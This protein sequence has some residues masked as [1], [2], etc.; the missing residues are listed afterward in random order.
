MIIIRYC[1]F[2]TKD[3]VLGEV[4]AKTTQGTKEDIDLAVE[5]ARTAFDTWSSLSNHTRALHIYSIARHVQKHMRLIS[6]IE[7]LDN[8]KPIRETRDYDTQVVARHLYHH[9]GWAELMDTEMKGMD[10]V[11]CFIIFKS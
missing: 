9:V 6:V 3:H 10:M 5:A 11:L 7:S 1:F 4:L 2:L 8:G